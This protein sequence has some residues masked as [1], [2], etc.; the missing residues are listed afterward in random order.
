M[1]FRL[2]TPRFLVLLA[3]GSEHEVQVLNPEL[4]RYEKTRHVRHWGSPVEDSATWSTFVVWA[5]LTREK[6][7]TMPFEQFAETDCLGLVPITDDEADRVD[8]TN[9]APETG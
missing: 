2:I 8:P 6:V 5:A 7:I 1:T 9:P 3:D 4:V